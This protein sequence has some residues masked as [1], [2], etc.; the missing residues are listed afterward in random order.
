[1]N[2]AKYEGKKVEI[3]DNKNQTWEGIVTDWFYPEDNDPERESIVIKCDIGRFV[4]SYVEFCEEEVQ[5]I[6]VLEK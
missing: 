3:I 4:G 1:M 6:K 2:L 5:T